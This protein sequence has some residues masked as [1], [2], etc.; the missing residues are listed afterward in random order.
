[1]GIIRFL[2][3]MAVIIAHSTPIFGLT[4]GAGVVVP[5]FFV[6]SGFYMALILSEKYIGSNSSY[7]LFISNR[8]LRLYP[9]Y[10]VI[11][12]VTLGANIYAFNHGESPKLNL[13]MELVKKGEFPIFGI[14]LYLFS[15][16]TLLFQDLISSIGIRHGA[17]F[18]IDGNAIST[19]TTLGYF[20]LVPQS[21]SL[22]SEI[23]FYV[24]APFIVRRSN[25][26]LFFLIT[27]CIVF[28]IIIAYMYKYTL[29]NQT[30]FPS[31]LPFFLLGVF[32]YRIY[33]LDLIKFKIASLKGKVIWSLPIFI[34]FLITNQW[35]SSTL[36]NFLWPII[37]S[38]FI[39]FILVYIR[40]RDGIPK[41]E[42]F[43]IPCIYPIY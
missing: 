38:L 20:N 1:M 23:L 19:V 29:W 25:K 3:S 31:V 12:I 2:L 11:L 43:L 30:L 22:G 14:I 34:V 7:W 13:M 21:W 35:L 17:L 28:R 39:P 4:F 5:C 33:K 9:I 10:F 26:M 40:K 8:I 27:L 24:L 36:S 32:S 16:I 42:N 37:F 18:F 41:L 15:S 6:I